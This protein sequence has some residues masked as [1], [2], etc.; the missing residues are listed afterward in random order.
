MIRRFSINF[1]IFSIFVD[2]FSIFAMLWLNVVIRPFI[3]EFL[4]VKPVL[5]GAFNLPVVLYVIFPLAWIAIMSSFSVYDGSKNLRVVDEFAS[6]TL[7][8]ILA[9]VALAG[10]LY[11]SYRDVSRAMFLIFG[12]MTYAVLLSWRIVAR[13]FYRLRHQSAEHIQHVLIIGAGPVGMDIAQR[14]GLHEWQG[15][16]IK[17]IGFLDDDL[18][19][20]SSYRGNVL[21]PLNTVRQVVIERHV[22]DVVFALPLR[23]HTRLSE[24]TKALLDLPVHTWVVPDYFQLALHQAKLADFVGVPML[25]LRAP[26]LSEYQ[27]Q[28]KRLFDLIVTSLLLVPALP[29]MGVLSLLILLLDG[30]PILFKQK[31]AGE[32][33]R[34]FTVY[35]FRTMIPNSEKLLLKVAEKD[36]QGNI[37]HKL[38]D[39]PRITPLG[40][41]LRRFSLDELPQLFNILSGSMSLVGPR[42]ELPELVEKY[43]PWQR[44]RFAIPQGLTGWW[45]IHGRS[46]KPMHLNTEEDLY[47]VHNYSFWLDIQI[48]ILT[49]WI[50]LR[51]KGAY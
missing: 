44:E 23:A 41:F 51:G 1:A 45:Q 22:D 34:L 18:Q 38:R 29:L 27:R 20:Q 46:D 2:A 6:L 5:F 19:K 28:V 49:F 35:K 16:G 14:L 50:V 4:P 26:A 17:L 7:S 8:S 33:G 39:D 3:D 15:H 25:D 47:Y 42:P 9:G 12:L 31:R 48:L 43:Q 40:R 13:F 37:I 36:V 21:G 30:R 32:N 24:L 10:I 11:L